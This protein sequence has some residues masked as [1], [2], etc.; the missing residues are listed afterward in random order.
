[1]LLESSLEIVSRAKDIDFNE[2]VRFSCFVSI[3]EPKNHKE[4]LIDEYC[5]RSMQ[6][7]MEQ[8]ERS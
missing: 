7:E 5:V 4:A 8:F 3:V 2:M 1:M 6:E